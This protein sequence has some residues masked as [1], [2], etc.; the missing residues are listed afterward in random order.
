MTHPLHVPPT[1]E[2]RVMVELGATLARARRDHQREVDALTDRLDALEQEVAFWRS[3][4]L[5][6]G[7]AA[8]GN[9]LTASQSDEQASDHTKRRGDDVRRSDAPVGGFSES[10]D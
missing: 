2:G 3:H 4:A 7:Y 1:L 6:L 10:S 5:A 8:H 9:R